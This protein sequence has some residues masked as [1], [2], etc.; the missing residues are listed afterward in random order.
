[1]YRFHSAP[2]TSGT[3]VVA[4]ALPAS[5]ASVDKPNCA[6]TLRVGLNDSM[7]LS[8]THAVHRTHCRAAAGG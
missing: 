2:P 6:S 1:M 5:R 4:M 3:G 8:A 7:G